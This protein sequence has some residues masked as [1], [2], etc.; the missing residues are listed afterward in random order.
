[1]IS[2]SLLNTVIAFVSFMTAAANRFFA[3]SRRTATHHG[4]EA[5]RSSSA[6]TSKAWSLRPV[7]SSCTTTID[8]YFM[9]D[10]SSEIETKIE[11]NGDEPWGKIEN[12]EENLK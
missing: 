7:F 6:G 11:Y 10:P 2:I 4:S 5:Q 8:G 9:P 1:V 3:D 12:C